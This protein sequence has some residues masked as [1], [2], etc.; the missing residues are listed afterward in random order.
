MQSILANI[1]ISVVYYI[2][3]KIVIG[4]FM[5]IF[6]SLVFLFSFGFAS[7]P[8]VHAKV[9]PSSY[10][11]RLPAIDEAN[12]SPNGRWL[13]TVVED[14]GAYVIRVFDLNN[15]NSK[16]VRTIGIGK[17]DVSWLK[18]VNNNQVLVSIYQTQQKGTLFYKTGSLI[19]IDKDMK[20]MRQVLQPKAR[21]KGASRFNKKVAFRQFNN[22]VVDF[23]PDDPS[24]ILMAFGEEDRLV[25]GVHKVSLKSA[26]TKK[27]KNGSRNTQTWITDLNGDVRIGLGQVEHNGDYHM[28]IYHDGKWLGVENYP[29]LEATTATFGFTKN[30]NEL[31]I[32]GYNGKETMGLYVY[33]LSLKKQ[34]RK[35]FHH[36]VYDVNDVVLSAD[37]KKIVGVSFTGDSHEIEFFDADYKEKMDKIKSKLEGYN[38]RYLDQSRDGKRV[39]FKASSPSIPN[40]LYM[41]DADIDKLQTLGYDYPEI[42]KTLQADVT[43]IRYTARDGYKIPGYI[44]TPPKIA[45]GEVAFKNLPFIILPHGGPY[46]RDTASFDVLAQFF[47]SRGYAVLQPNYRGSAGLGASH[48]QARRK[49]WEVMQEDVEDGTRW[50]IK[51]GYA[52]PKRICIVG[53]FYGGYAAL[54]GAIKSPELYTCSASIAGLTDPKSHVYD[55]KRF[56][57]GKYLAKSFILAGFEDGD[58]IKE[59]SPVKRAS[60]IKIPVFLAHGTMDARVNI[61][62]YRSMKRALGTGVD[63]VFIEFKGGDHRLINTAHR[64]ELFSKLDIFL[65]KYL[66]ESAAAP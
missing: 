7:V 14:R 19:V 45:D 18:W 63:K 3:N 43:K 62:Q 55:L 13:A 44:T 24:H 4:G 5:R 2:H 46:A 15:L 58:D 66:G 29:G 17:V 48:L 49:N 37:G 59:N 35:L 57:H 27:V 34:T 11:S 50:L 53:W 40:I 16:K 54:M 31:I 39:I 25:P 1:R 9:L 12:I 20:E 26:S 52:D 47:A 38:I 36:D 30:P 51:K 28:S 64:N 6:L 21:Q 42:G 65:G 41:Y 23:L 60:E 10:Y 22:V 8:L 32:G 33:D 56:L 61:S